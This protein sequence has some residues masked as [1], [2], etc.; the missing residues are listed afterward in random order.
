MVTAIAAERKSI[1][2]GNGTLVWLGRVSD[3]GN[4]PLYRKPVGY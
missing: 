1:A 4:V 2:T 3:L